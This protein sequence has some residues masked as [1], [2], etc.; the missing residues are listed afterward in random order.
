MV[1]TKDIRNKPSD[2]VG[3]VAQRLNHDMPRSAAKRKVQME[4]SGRALGVEIALAGW[5]A[6]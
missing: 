3:V 6:G 5:L 1:V 2:V 4:V